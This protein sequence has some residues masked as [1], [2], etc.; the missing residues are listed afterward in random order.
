[1]KKP[2][3]YLDELDENVIRKDI[4]H[5]CENSLKDV[6]LQDNDETENL[7]MHEK[8]FNQFSYNPYA[9]RNNCTS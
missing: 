1:M 8:M 3:K 7:I 5:S 2:P 9:H 4:I 6:E